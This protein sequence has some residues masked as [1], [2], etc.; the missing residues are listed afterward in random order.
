MTYTEH[1]QK[2]AICVRLA[3]FL[4]LVDFLIA[5]AMQALAVDSLAYLRDH[6]ASVR[7]HALAVGH[8][9]MEHA[10]AAAILAAETESK[11]LTAKRKKSKGKATEIVEVAPKLPG[12]DGVPLPGGVLQL[13]DAEYVA[14]KK[15]TTDEDGNIK[16]IVD[17]A[18][19]MIKVTPP[20]SRLS[21]LIYS[22]IMTCCCCCCY[23]RLSA[24]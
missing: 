12:K 19:P 24:G 10:T 7:A 16:L 8:E 14:T 23:S 18:C 15:L 13:G 11:E 5:N 20:C 6:L 2:R 1:G 4:R 21:L 3:N 22:M 9:M 17:E